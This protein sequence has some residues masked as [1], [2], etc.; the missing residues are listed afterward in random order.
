[1]TKGSEVVDAERECPDIVFSPAIYPLSDL[2][3]FT[4]RR[5]HG[6]TGESERRE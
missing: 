1:M 6:R 3:D 5:W 4:C 2:I